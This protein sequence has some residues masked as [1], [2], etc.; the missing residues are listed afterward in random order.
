MPTTAAGMGQGFG[1]APRGDYA[2]TRLGAAPPTS[3]V[4][5]RQAAAVSMLAAA[6][7]PTGML[8]GGGSA[9]EMRE[10][11]RQFLHG[12]VSPIALRHAWS[13]GNS[14][15]LDFAFNFDRLFAADLSGRARAFQS[16]VN[17]GMEVE[18]A[19]GL[20]QLMNPD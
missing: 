3:T 9:T 6:G 19:A 8:H 7:V 18:K 14:F 16:M 13:I 11:Y 20:A 10:S 2:V 17:G 4:E 15:E 12:S 5:L 1:A